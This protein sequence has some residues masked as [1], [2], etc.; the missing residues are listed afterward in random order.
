MFETEG[1]NVR[2]VNQ[3]TSRAGLPYN[4]LEHSQMRSSFREDGQRRRR[5]NAIQIL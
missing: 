3:V 4:S 1:H 5:Q 2:I